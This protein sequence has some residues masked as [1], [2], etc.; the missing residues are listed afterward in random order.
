[1]YW[2]GSIHPYAPFPKVKLPSGWKKR[3]YGCIVKKRLNQGFT[4]F[5][6]IFSW[7]NQTIHPYGCIR[8]T[9]VLKHPYGGFR[10]YGCI[11]TIFKQ[12]SQVRSVICIFSSGNLHF[13]WGIRQF[14]SGICYFSSGNYNFHS[15]LWQFSSGICKVSSGNSNFPS[16]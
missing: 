13:P 6:E 14:C 16:G 1:M 11:I 4:W 2:A 3:P 5:L 8:H 10:A 7:G 15:G 9:D 12:L